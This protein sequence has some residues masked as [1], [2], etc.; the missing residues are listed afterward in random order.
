MA[1]IRIGI[2]GVKRDGDL[3][4][5]TGVM[6]VDRSTAKY[7]CRFSEDTSA[8]LPWVEVSES[9]DRLKSEECFGRSVV[10]GRIDTVRTDAEAIGHPK[11]RSA[12]PPIGRRGLPEEV[13]AMVRMLCGPNARYITGQAIHI[14]GGRFMP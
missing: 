12:V 10:P 1:L 11:H 8:D 3:V 14:N 4:R 13:A 2:R 9:R 7:S 6:T 5:S